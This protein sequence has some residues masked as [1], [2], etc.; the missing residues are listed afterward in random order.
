[1]LPRRGGKEHKLEILTRWSE[2]VPIQHGS[3]P[4]IL[5]TTRHQQ[6]IDS[7]R[8]ALRSAYRATGPTKRVLTAQTFLAKTDFA[9]PPPLSAGATSHAV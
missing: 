7:F 1:M 9:P 8:H 2:G 3:I 4:S 5:R 6:E